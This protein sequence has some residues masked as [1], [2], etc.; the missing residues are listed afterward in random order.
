MP[1]KFGI[2]A[3][4]CVPLFAG[5]TAGATVC[6]KAG[7]AAAAANVTNKRKS[8]CLCMPN[9]LWWFSAKR[10]RQDTN[11]LTDDTPPRSRPGPQRSFCLDAREFDYLAPLLGVS[12]DELAEV[13]GRH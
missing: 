11:C 1:E 6:P 12:G 13:G 9:S 8:R 10:L 4:L 2:D 5:P 3:A 7:V